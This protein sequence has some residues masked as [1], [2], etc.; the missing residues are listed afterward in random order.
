MSC[1][2]TLESN[3]SAK[4]ED[5]RA[6]SARAHSH[7]RLFECIPRV[8]MSE[9]W[10][11]RRRLDAAHHLLTG[12]PSELF[13]K[14]A[15]NL[16]DVQDRACFY[17]AMTSYH[18]RLLKLWIDK[19]HK[20]LDMFIGVKTRT[21]SPYFL[22]EATMRGYVH[23]WGATVDGAMLLNKTSANAHKFEIE[24]IEDKNAGVGVSNTWYLKSYGKTVKLRF[25]HYA[26]NQSLLYSG[27]AQGKEYFFKRRWHGNLDIQY[28]EGVPPLLKKMWVN[29][30]NAMQFY[31]KDENGKMAARVL[32]ETNGSKTYFEGNAN[33][34][35]CTR[36]VCKDVVRHFKGTERGKERLAMRERLDAGT[37]EYFTGEHRFERMYAWEDDKGNRFEFARCSS[38]DHTL[39]RLVTVI[40]IQG[41][42]YTLEG[43]AYEE[44][45]VYIFNKTT[46]QYF[47]L[48]GEKGKEKYVMVVKAD[49]NIDESALTTLRGVKLVVPWKK[50]RPNS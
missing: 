37:V 40:T 14:V 47:G 12:L 34:E 22:T 9:M 44:H 33:K 35:Y 17:Y 39:V 43:K 41:H 1:K 7:G 29:D 2:R 11:K 38:M 4:N 21:A 19:E 5:I 30:R 46:G 15:N 28:Y 25:N 18:R 45:V 6:A 27:E 20:K 48:R 8:R 42:I 50:T 36:T 10:S 16:V 26:E 31:E 32:V 3:T 23:Q 24:V 13:L 49:G